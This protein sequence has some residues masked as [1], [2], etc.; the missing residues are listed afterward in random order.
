MKRNTDLK[1]N[2]YS[3]EWNFGSFL[4]DVLKHGVNRASKILIDLP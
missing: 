4:E 3:H 2:A 1:N